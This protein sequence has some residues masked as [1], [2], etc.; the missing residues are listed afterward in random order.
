MSSVPSVWRLALKVAKPPKSRK[1]ERVFCGSA[2]LSAFLWK[3]IQEW[4]GAKEVL[5]AYGITET[6]SWVAGTTVPGFVPEDGLI[7]EPWGAIV[8]VLRSG[9]TKE[10][11]AFMEVCEPGEAGVVWLNTPALMKGYFGRDDLTSQVVNQGWFVTGDIGYVDERG[12]LYLRGRERE[13]INKGGLKVY[14]GDIDA[15]VERFERVLDVCCFGYDDDPLYG[16]NVG[17]A[18]VMKD[19]SQESLRLLYHWTKQHLAEYQMP[20][21]WYLV[22]A[23]PRTSRGK[24]NRTQVAHVCSSLPPI[25]L[26]RLMKAEA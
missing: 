8:R 6:G 11:L 4:T 25:D 3:A 22:D 19:G 26:A 14:P 1:L 21:R 16:Q 9:T 15:V 24:I 7:G 2:P 13:E 12:W 18:V 23:I 17:V 10:P 20:V 5:N